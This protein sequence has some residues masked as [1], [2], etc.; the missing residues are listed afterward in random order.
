MSKTGDL[1]LLGLVRRFRAEDKVFEIGSK[2]FRVCEGILSSEDLSLLK[3]MQSL[4]S[5]VP[6][7]SLILE[8]SETS[9]IFFSSYKGDF[10]S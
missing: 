1:G 9:R 10:S 3:S 8:T 5:L 4:S 2:S 7:C 6:S